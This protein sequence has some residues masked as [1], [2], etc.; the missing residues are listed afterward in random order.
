[1]YK[2]ELF[3]SMQELLK[4]LNDNKISERDIVAIMPFEA[5]NRS[6]EANLRREYE[7]IYKERDKSCKI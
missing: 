7:M 1:M 6:G 5:Y 3:E 2:R 4:F